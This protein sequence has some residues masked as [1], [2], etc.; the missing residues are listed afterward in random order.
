MNTG[1]PADFYRFYLLYIRPETHDA[2]FKWS[3]F[4]HRV[5]S[6]LNDNV[7]NFIHR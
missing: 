2:V 3:D 4:I 1:I 5:N 7:G 6:E